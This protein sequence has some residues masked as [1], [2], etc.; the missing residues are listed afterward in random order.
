MLDVALGRPW[1]RQSVFLVQVI[2]QRFVALHQ[3]KT[4]KTLFLNITTPINK[5]L[6][7]TSRCEL[8]RNL[9][10]LSRGRSEVVQSNTRVPLRWSTKKKCPKFRITFS[11]HACK[12]NVGISEKS[13][14]KEVLVKYL[15]S[16]E[17]IPL[18]GP[19]T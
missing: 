16:Y 19:R 4:S 1:D 11:R 6:T 14:T 9:F 13:S 8:K 7:Q 18:E 3:T 5:L 10:C 15:G 12:K 17:K 2:P